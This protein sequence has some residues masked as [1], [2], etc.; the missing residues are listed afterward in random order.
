MK[1]TAVIDFKEKRLSFFDKGNFKFKAENTIINAD[2]IVERPDEYII[3]GEVVRMVQ[4]FDFSN[5]NEE[6][7]TREQF[8]RLGIKLKFE[9]FET[10]MVEVSRSKMLFGF[11]PWIETQTVEAARVPNGYYG[12]PDDERYNVEVKIP[13]SEFV[14]F[15]Y[16]DNEDD[17]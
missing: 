14:I 5:E 6:W 3:R 4:V 2:D 11:I 9:D 12:C 13:K 16:Q 8:N 17:K 1:G 7:Y 10:K 15:N